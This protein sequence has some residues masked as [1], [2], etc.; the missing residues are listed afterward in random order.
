MSLNRPNSVSAL[1]AEPRRARAALL[2]A[3]LALALSVA[4]LAGRPASVP[5]ATPAT[6]PINQIALQ[7]TG[8]NTFT[9][10]PTFVKLLKKSHAKIKALN[11]A[12]LRGKTVTE[13][14]N[15]TTVFTVSP[16]S[17]DVPSTGTIQF[18]RTDSRKVEIKN[19]SLSLNETGLPT[20]TGTLRGKPDQQFAA[21][22][23][24]P[25][26]STNQVGNGY[27][28]IDVQLLIS[29]QLATALK[30]AHIKNAKP[31]N[32]LGLMTTSVTAN[33]P[34]FTLPTLGG[35]NGLGGLIPG[36]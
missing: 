33:L 23:L 19:I 3:G 27:Q 35:T 2:L 29:A 15:A 31:G 18:R 7:V 13:Q 14:I 34:S 26:T 16:A 28:F 5:A 20:L 1:A 22:S 10:D 17:V 32:L 12:K 11:G 9:F 8:Q 24:S 25:T 4:L 21:L 6:T 36:L 30:A